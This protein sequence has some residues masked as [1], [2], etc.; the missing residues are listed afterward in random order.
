MNII[1]DLVQKRSHSDLFLRS[2]HT[3]KALIAARLLC[4][5]HS[6]SKQV[7]QLTAYMPS[8]SGGLLGS[9]MSQQYLCFAVLTPLAPP[10]V[11]M[12]GE[13]LG[14]VASLPAHIAIDVVDYT[15]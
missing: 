11:V 8:A 7:W 6:P 9:S 13:P 1:T 4:A 14:L 10:R 2:P 15:C 3:S 5:C 12:R